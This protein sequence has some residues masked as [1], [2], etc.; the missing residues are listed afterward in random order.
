MV[1]EAS[2]PTNVFLPESTY[3][4]VIFVVLTA[5]IDGYTAAHFLTRTDEITC[6]YSVWLEWRHLLD[7]A[8]WRL[9]A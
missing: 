4:E 3:D 6:W 2:V 1:D 9:H 5:C 8:N 7:E